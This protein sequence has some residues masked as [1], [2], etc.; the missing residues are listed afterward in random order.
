MALAAISLIDVLRLA[1]MPNY[2]ELCLLIHKPEC[3]DV[4]FP[5]NF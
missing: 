4:F 5:S 2:N 1:D 3:R